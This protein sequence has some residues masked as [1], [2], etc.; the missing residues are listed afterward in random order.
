MLNKNINTMEEKLRKFN[1][2]LEVISDF[3]ENQHLTFMVV[4]SGALLTCGIPIKREVGDI[5]IEVCCDEKEARVFKIL[6]DASFPQYSQYQILKKDKPYI[7]TY[8][9][10]KVNVWVVEE[11]T[12]KQWVEKNHIRFATVYSVL[13]RKMAYKR[14]K[15]FDDLN[16]IAKALLGTIDDPKS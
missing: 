11:F 10:I 8:K 16:H 13:Q 4:G 15:D 1:R 7:F 12:H 5:D 9:G 6:Q 3:L 2:D 14:V